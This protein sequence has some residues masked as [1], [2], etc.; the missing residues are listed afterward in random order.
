MPRVTLTFTL[1]EEQVEL[2]TALNASAIASLMERIDRE[3]RAI[4]K[5]AESPSKDLLAFVD[6][7]RKSISEVDV[8]R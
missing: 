8:V 7:V 2:D 6:L 4:Q 5:Y 3:A 1:P